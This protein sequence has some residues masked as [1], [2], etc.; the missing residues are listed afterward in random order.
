MSNQTNGNK[1][2]G[3]RKPKNNPSVHRYV[4]RLTA[5]ENAGFLSRFE[6]S[7]MAN[8]AKFIT[9]VMLNREIRTVKIDFAA[10]EFH[11]MLTQFYGQ[12]RSVGVNYNQIV[13]L[14]YHHFSE[15]KAAAYLYKLEKQTIELAGIC[16]K[17]VQ[18]SQEFETE[19]LKKES[20]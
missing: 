12:F 8:K 16:Q 3:G 20:K 5:E 15:K 14:L 17:V 13:K 4:F 9:S 19:H 6:Q 18:L 1:S 2:N 7:G 10:M 11:T